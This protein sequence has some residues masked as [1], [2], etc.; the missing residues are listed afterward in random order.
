MRL[1]R[2][3]N[4]A[5]NMSFLDVMACG[6][7]AVI[8]IFILVD[9]YAATIDPSDELNRLDAEIAAA[10][11]DEIEI[12]EAIEA[13][14]AAI[15]EEQARQDGS[16]EAQQLTLAQQQQLLQQ[17]ST[18]L[19]VIADLEEQLAALADIET[20]DS[21]IRLSGT[22]EENYI[23]GMVVEGRQIG[24]LFDKSASMMGDSLVDVLL[25][26]S[27]APEQ[28]KR[29]AKWQRN[30]RAAKWLLARLPETSRVTVV[31]FSDSASVLGPNN[32]NPVP[33]TSSLRQIADEIDDVTPDGG[34]N[35]LL[36]MQTLLAANPNITDIY[37][38]T[39]GLPTLGEGL[40]LRCRNFISRQRSISS[41]CRQ[42]LLLE[43]VKRVPGNYRMNIILLPLEGD[44][45]APSMYWEW[46]NS[47]QGRFLAPSQEWP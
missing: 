26:L 38:V 18:E 1:K 11:S 14:L 5:F 7:G 42:E 44:P 27:Y 12:S 33:A 13:T 37:L 9:F 24:I 21:N 46:A 22:G 34:T 17:L 4:D 3:N 30:V 40:G 16:Q 8:L 2:R 19:A 23:T 43:T 45:F 39:D 32:V 20:P 35:L 36:G 25:A 10:T 47:T 29:T 31:S 15:A 41:E 28:R 6:L